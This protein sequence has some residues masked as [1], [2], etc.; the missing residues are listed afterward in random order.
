MAWK[1]PIASSI[2]KKKKNNNIT[3]TTDEPF[4][5]GRALLVVKTPIKSVPADMLPFIQIIITI[6]GS[7]CRTG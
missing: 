5:H 3:S 6:R 4:P 7:F 2:L 1:I